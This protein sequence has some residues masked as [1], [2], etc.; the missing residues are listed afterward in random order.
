MLQFKFII[1]QRVLLEINQFFSRSV[2]TARFSQEAHQILNKNY[3]FIT[4]TTVLMIIQEVLP[5]ALE[6]LVPSP[7]KVTIDN[8][9]SNHK[10]T[11]VFYIG[12]TLQTETKSIRYYVTNYSKINLMS[13]NTRQCVFLLENICKHS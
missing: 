13:C 2:H 7:V 11:S 9:V 3:I 12:S 1:S 4:V 5:K 6:S 8:I 10:V